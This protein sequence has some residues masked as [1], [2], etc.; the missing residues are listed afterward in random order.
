MQQLEEEFEVEKDFEFFRNLKNPKNKAYP[1][2]PRQ[3]GSV[4]KPFRELL[5]I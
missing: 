2:A 3:C 5:N 1:E 4:I